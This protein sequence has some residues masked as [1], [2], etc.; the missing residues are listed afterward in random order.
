MTHDPRATDRLLMST[1]HDIAFPILYQHDLEALELRGH[2]KDVRRDD[3]LFAEGDR[4]FCFFVVLE[5]SI[6]IL[7]H[8]SGTP[9]T[10]TV[11]GA[12]EFTG[13]VDMLTGRAALVTGRMAEDGRVLQLNTAEL[14][15]AVD[16]LPELGEIILKAF[17]MRR[18]LLLSGGF[19]GVK[20]VGS[21][22]SADA[23]RLRDFATRNAV[24]FT[25]IDLEM[26]EQAEALLRQFGVPPSATPIVIERD[27]QWMSNP[28]ITDFAHY[29]GLAAE[30]APGHVYDLVIVGA[31]PAG[32]AAS[33][34]AASEG[35]DVLTLDAVAAGGQAGTSSRIENYL[36]FP[37]GISGAELT[38]NAL[39]Q[40]QK[41]GACIT[42]PATVTALRVDGGERAV[43]LDDN[44]EVRARC[45]LVASGVAYRK[46][47]VAGLADFD[48]AGV[49]YAATD[50]EARLCRGE[51]VVV[52]GAGN[53]AGQAIVYLSRYAKHVHVL[54]RG[55]DL[56][57]S[58]SRYLVDRVEGID[59][60]TIYRETT[61]SGVEGT[62]YLDTV[63][64][65]T[66]DGTEHVFHTT[67]LFLFTGADPKTAWLSRCL[68]LDSKGFVLTGTQLSPAG[69]TSD[70]W[71]VAG[72]RP[73][74]LETSLP[75]IFAAGD[76]RSGSVKRVA[77]AVGEGAMAVS[78]VHAHIERPV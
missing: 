73:F 78:F 29:L 67:S 19:E 18:T 48:G 75:G 58:M 40:A 23:H 32:L 62:K 45:V 27:G 24:P 3:V 9:H 5:G 13:D 37:T 10:V 55:T 30:P 42:V 56:G 51:D 54:V 34:Y 12:G 20:I 26:D 39:L 74:L 60:V 2:V 61:V 72:R 41:F 71:R 28:S 53:S 70:A 35:L 63:R 1:D 38:R 49:Y 15:R 31:G 47:D 7:E 50:M 4:N 64:A 46:I 66:R 76:V 16:E 22:F 21:R 8:A 25:W 6:E 17:L 65:T 43:L 69:T 14:R 68:E 36:G 59:N 57:A 44:T 11:H 52:I 33:V 77:S